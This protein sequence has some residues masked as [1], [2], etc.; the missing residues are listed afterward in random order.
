[1]QRS[2]LAQR[3]LRFLFSA[4]IGSLGTMLLMVNFTIFGDHVN[5]NK[6]SLNNSPTTIDNSR[7]ITI[8]DNTNNIDNSV[9]IIDNSI[10]LIEENLSYLTEL[11]VDI[12]V[13]NIRAEITKI[14]RE[15]DEIKQN[16]T[17]ID[18]SLI[19]QYFWSQSSPCYKQ[20]AQLKIPHYPF[21]Q[22]TVAPGGSQYWAQTPESILW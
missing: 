9:T 11:D 17:G 10:T 6:S 22:V 21:Y 20:S 5:G 14:K 15:T 4:S 16:A 18:M 3:L 8:T 7:N 2:G 13:D 19:Q 12:N 1:M